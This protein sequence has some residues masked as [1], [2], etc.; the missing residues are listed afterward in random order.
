[1]S[2]VHFQG[3][4][5]GEI[6]IAHVALERLLIGVIR[7]VELQDVLGP[8]FETTGRTLVTQ[9][10]R[11]TFPVYSKQP[12]RGEPF[13]THRTFGLLLVIVLRLVLLLI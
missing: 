3:A 9:G 7:L 5:T 1:M 12:F 8:E 10:L 6:L 2:L 13:E 11:V 4:S